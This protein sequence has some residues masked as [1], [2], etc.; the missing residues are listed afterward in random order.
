VL[1]ALAT[2]YGIANEE[3]AAAPADDPGLAP[4]TV[5]IEAEPR[6]LPVAVADMG[7]L[8]AE[9]ETS[10]AEAPDPAPPVVRWPGPAGVVVVSANLIMRRQ[11][12][13]VLEAGA[14]EIVVMT[15]RD[16]AEARAV[17][18]AGR[19]HVLLV[20]GTGEAIDAP[21]WQRL[22]ADVDAAL[23]VLTDSRRTQPAAVVPDRVPPT[24]GLDALVASVRRIL[25]DQR[26]DPT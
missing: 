5:R 21:A 2:W 19:V 10:E 7:N 22:A 11:T 4:A 14:L 23:V 6:E 15:V 26:G 13:A 9:P 24:T 25:I 1:R 18:A 8:L 3:P 12:S 20:D 16:A 17:A